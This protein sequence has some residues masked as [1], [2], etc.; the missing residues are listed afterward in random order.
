MEKIRNT[1][2][3]LTTSSNEMYEAINSLKEGTLNLIGEVKKFK[4]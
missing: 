4:V 2:G 1:T 3:N